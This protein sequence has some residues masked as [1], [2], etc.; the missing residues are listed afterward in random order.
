MIEK[1]NLDH[2]AV[3][4]QQ[5]RFPENIGAA[6]RAMCN[7]GLR[8]LIVVCPENCDR[9]RMFKM[10]THEASDIIERMQIA[11]ELKQT[12]SDFQYVVGTTAR[13]GGERKVVYT[14]SN[15]A[16][17]LISISKENQVALVFGPEN[18]GLNN[19]EARNC[20][21]LVNI[22]TAQFSSLNLAQAVMVMCYELFVAGSETESAFVPRM[23]NHYELDG[24]YDQLKQVLVNISYIN[25]DNPD[26]WMTKIRQSLN[27]I[28][29]RARDVKIIRG[30]CRQIN[31]YGEKC[32]QDGFKAGQSP[33]PQ[34]EDERLA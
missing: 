23:A 22:P 29:L 24:M 6:A 10:A 13:L 25:A 4:L 11:D 15:L 12:L 5:P 30:L 28:C 7:M 8:R 2:I 17:K 31:W 21:V 1:I 26:Y 34:P 3:V 27:R 32:Y 33:E 14:P 9:D 20:H 19:E 16:Q 18:R